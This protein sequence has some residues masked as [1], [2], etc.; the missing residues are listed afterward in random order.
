MRGEGGLGSTY[1]LERPESIEAGDR[2][3][4]TS[5]RSL[6]PRELTVDVPVQW[7][8]PMHSSVAWREWLYMMPYQTSW[9]G[10]M[11]NKEKLLLRQMN[12]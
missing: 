6:A 11:G 8:L 7:D 1:F 5:R 2:L 10:F 9:N 12:E 4:A 3:Q